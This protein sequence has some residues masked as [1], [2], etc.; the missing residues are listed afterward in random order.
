MPIACSFFQ[1]TYWYYWRGLIQSKSHTLTSCDIGFYD[2]SS[3]LTPTSTLS[4][5]RFHRKLLNS[6]PSKT[7]LV[8]LH[9]TDN[10]IRDKIIIIL[11]MHWMFNPR[12]LTGQIIQPGCIDINK[13]LYRKVLSD[14]V[15]ITFVTKAF[16]V[17]D[18]KPVIDLS[19]P[20][21]TS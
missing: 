1:K 18:Q 7:Y 3:V 11:N 5:S 15:R 13:H 10:T 2:T 14:Q 20:L 19:L 17:I 12:W 4:Y 21:D 8:H 9:T 16:S 6:I